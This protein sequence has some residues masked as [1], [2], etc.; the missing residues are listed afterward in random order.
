[1]CKIIQISKSNLTKNRQP[2]ILSTKGVKLKKGIDVRLKM[3]STNSQSAETLQK[4]Q[5]S[6]TMTILSVKLKLYSCAYKDC[7][8][9]VSINTTLGRKTAICINFH[10]D[11][12]CCILFASRFSPFFQFTDELRY[13]H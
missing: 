1:M 10:N 4:Q 11:I 13:S 5:P 3:F 12:N 6:R 8:Y 9:Y 7:L 2:C